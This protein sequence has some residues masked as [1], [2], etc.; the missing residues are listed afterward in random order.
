MVKK[1]TCY[2]SRKI[3]VSRVQTTYISKGFSKA[4]CSMSEPNIIN[5]NPILNFAS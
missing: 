1:N 5:N 4:K 3:S 2:N